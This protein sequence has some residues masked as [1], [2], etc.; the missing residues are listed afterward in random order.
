MCDFWSTILLGSGRYRGNP[1][2]THRTIEHLSR[3][4]F[5]RWLE[6]FEQVVREQFAMAPAE[7]LIERAHRMGQTLQA[8]LPAQPA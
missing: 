6:L 4:H 1:L 5:R 3:E 7:L 8:D 2:Q